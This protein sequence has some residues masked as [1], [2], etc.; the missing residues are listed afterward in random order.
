MKYRPEIDGLRGLAVLPVV[1]YHAHVPG[2]GGGFVGVDVFFVISGYLITGLI[3]GDLNQ[4]RFSL[5]HFYERRVRRILPAL[6]LVAAVCL[7]VAWLVYLPNEFLGFSRSLAAL[8][9]FSTNFLFWQESGYFDAPAE[10]KPLLH[11]WSLAVEEQFYL[12]FPLGLLLALRFAR[13]R[14][15]VV[16]AA[17][18]LLSFVLSVWATQHVPIANFFLLPMRAWELFLG[19]GLALAGR[20]Q[21]RRVWVAELAALV[22]LAC[23][24]VAVTTFN[25]RTPFPGWA[26]VLPCLGAALVIW[27]TQHNDTFSR[28]ALSHR[29]P[30]HIGLLS[31][32]LYL[33]HWPL[34]VFSRRI[35]D[36]SLTTPETAFVLGASFVLSWISWRLVE[37]PVR[38]RH[39]LSRRPALFSATASF[40]TVLGLAGLY[41]LWS[42]GAPGRLFPQALHYADG[43][44]DRNPRHEECNASLGERAVKVCEIGRSNQRAPRF[45]V[46][47]DSHADAMLS[48]FEDMAAR[49]GVNGLFASRSACPPLLGVSR[50]FHPSERCRESNDTMLPLVQKN[51]IPHVIL[52]AR[53]SVYV[54]EEN[55]FLEDD[56]L[57]A[58]SAPESRIVFSR[59]LARTTRALA[60]LGA[61]VWIVHQVPVYSFSPPRTLVQATILG[62]DVKRVGMT[63]D[64]HRQQ[65][66]FVEELL[67][68]SANA[69]VLFIDPAARLC[70][71]G[72]FCITAAD[73]RSLYRDK[74]HMSA[75]GA[76][77]ISPVFG[78]VFQAISARRE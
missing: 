38:K 71:D 31:Y 19:A 44:A 65:R 33:W 72:D 54:T 12:L 11:T 37:Q 22:G 36:R 64:E 61:T 17:L 45:L 62:R 76:R 41:G 53:W 67:A 32:S 14:V 20:Q 56:L 59:A 35:L 47:G 26:A 66:A 50:T 70:S 39:I 75:F 34:L 60:R 13:V 6:G 21:P 73:G 4:G 52:I 23:V 58:K 51:H 9:V 24:L 77:W 27:S 2:F 69:R 5:V 57:E 29:W 30:V 3:L 18:G 55:T 49:Y 1:L 78:P 25:E 43:T 8:C 10:E 16:I 46:W 42:G 68:R 7:V 48:A 28:R 74:N 15:H 63:L 40:F